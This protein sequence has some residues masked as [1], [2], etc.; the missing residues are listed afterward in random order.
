MNALLGVAQGSMRPPR[1]LVMKWD[2][3]GGA[4]TTPTVFIGKGVTFDSGGISLK[5][6]AG[7]EEMK[8][9][10]GGAGAMAGAKMALAMRTAKAHAV[11]ICGMVEHRPDARAWRTSATVPTRCRERAGVRHNAD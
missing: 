6:G 7:M 9:D 3:T 10:R 4:Q 2:G 11:G 5:T 8:W 1:L